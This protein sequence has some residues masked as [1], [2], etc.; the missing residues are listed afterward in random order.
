MM[1]KGAKTNQVAVRF[2]LDSYARINDYAISEH[3]GIGEFVRH[4]TLF[5]MEHFDGARESIHRER[6]ISS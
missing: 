1:K 4:A 6:E 3:R 2:D 5:Y